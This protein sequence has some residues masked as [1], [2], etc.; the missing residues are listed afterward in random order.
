MFIQRIVVPAV[1]PTFGSIATAGGTITGSDNG[2]ER[3]WV[4]SFTAIPA[5]GYTSFRALGVNSS[6]FGLFSTVSL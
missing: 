1:V 6:G 3:Y 2:L 4:Y 5:T